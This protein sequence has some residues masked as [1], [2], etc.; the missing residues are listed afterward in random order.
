MSTTETQFL[1]E[2]AESEYE[3]GWTTDIPYDTAPPGLNEDTIRF[4]SAKKEEP[5]WL[6]EWRLRAFRHFLTLMEDESKYPR[7]AHLK[8]VE[9]N[10][11]SIRDRKS[12]RLNSSHVA[13][14]Y[15]VFCLKKKIHKTTTG[16]DFASG[17]VLTMFT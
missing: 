14:S 15:A 9:P 12:T 13:I 5:E 2:V 16:T 6:L 3:H 4:I 17:D 1:Q 8:Y 11:Q 10:L 7:W